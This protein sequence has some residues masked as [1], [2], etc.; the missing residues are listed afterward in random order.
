MRNIGSF[1]LLCVFFQLSWA[2]DAPS[3][4]Q[5]QCLLAL[6]T[7]GAKV[8]ETAAADALNCVRSGVK[9]KL[10]SGEVANCLAGGSTALEKAKANTAAVIAKSC[11]EMPG[12]GP[13]SAQEINAA[14]AGMAD[15]KRL[16]GSDLPTTLKSS[17][18]NKNTANCQL[19]MTQQFS[20][21]A[22]A[23]VV[24]Y[25]KCVRKKLD[26]GQ[27]VTSAD[28]QSC[29]GVES[30]ALQKTKAA[31]IKQVAK[32]CKTVD[33][34]SVCPGQCA[35]AANATELAACLA[36]QAHCGSCEAVNGADRLSAGCHQYQDGIATQ[37]CGTRPQQHHTVARLWN[38]QNLDA[39]RID[40]PRP[41]V[42]ARN[43]FH[44]SVAMYDAWAAY[45]NKAKA[46]M[47][48]EHPV[49]TDSQHDRDAAI[50]FAAYR[51]LSERYS[52]KL[53]LGYKVSQVRFE[54][55][56]NEL[57]YDT[58]YTS[59]V[60][61]GPA[62]VGNR[63]AAA[64]I[65]AG[66]IDGS[67]EKI[68]YADPT[69]KAVNKPMI[70]KDSD[71]ALTDTSD[72]GYRLDPNRW[73]PLAL[74]KTV[75][76]N[77][78]PL[79]DKVQTF[80]GSQW[81][82]VAPFAMVKAAGEDLYHDPG[83]PPRLGGLGDAKFKEEVLKVIEMD[84]MLSPD[85]GVM[86]D[87]SPASVGNNPLGTN[88]GTGY[89]V[90]P[91]TGKP[92]VP[93]NVPRGDFGRVLAEYWADGPTSETPPGH[94]NSI[95][96]AVADTAGFQHR[97]AGK[98]A[99]LDRLE[100]DVKSYFAL[101]GATHDAAIACWGGKRKYDGVRPITMVRY[102][103]KKGQSSDPSLPSYD[104]MGLL[105]KPGVVEL[106]TADTAKPGQR[107]A[108]LVATKEGGKLGD[109][110]VRSWPGSPADPKTQINGVRWVLGKAWVPY[111]RSTFVTPAFPGYFS[112]HSTFSRSAAE[113]LAAITGSEYFPGGLMEYV[114]V[115]DKSL[116]HEKGPSQDV[117]LQW[118]TYFDAADQ[119]GISRLW[120]GIHVAADDFTGRRTGHLIGIEAFNKAM[121]YFDGSAK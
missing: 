60:G 4:A 113:V 38:E 2:A 57:G 13:G 99:V 119:A 5:K 26:K 20:T 83:A 23:E 40:T 25:G 75:T 19:A 30:A 15:L 48:N 96:N 8:A 86:M 44:L 33:I 82:E 58:R 12:F 97:V 67:N 91:V 84:S 1:L 59:L 107:H 77:G 7:A 117:Y 36:A 89:P 45:D 85:D 102:M 16:F 120:G 65:A 62:A 43:L 9:G 47:T 10:S 42:H 121:T 79:P 61:N 50:S 37:Y 17:A 28:L 118:A 104:P 32:Q 34:A 80:I 55:Q 116:I 53:A 35:L 24:E 31:A 41:P 76:Q 93:Q 63:I 98:G 95:A 6:E 74:D 18:Q 78:I 56:M 39:I 103:A 29:S 111:Q 66:L 51:V 106:I 14:Y 11:D 100:W 112:G 105:L 21:V 81:G 27:I 114:S 101:N 46:Y 69:Y 94:W 52:D 90:N 87:S 115:K 72:A 71:I 109:I 68:N 3:K 64:V 49:S 70:V 108:A 22:K 54:K 92:Y 88:D 110:A 73:Q